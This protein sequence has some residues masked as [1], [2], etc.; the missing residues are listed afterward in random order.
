MSLQESIL[1]ESPNISFVWIF[2]FIFS[3]VLQPLIAIYEF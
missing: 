1:M 2:R 3:F